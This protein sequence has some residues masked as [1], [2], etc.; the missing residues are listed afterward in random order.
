MLESL[1][2]WIFRHGRRQTFAENPNL[3]EEGQR[4]AQDLLLSVSE[5][6]IPKPTE[7]L[8]SP[9][10]RA[11][12]TFDLLA[13]SLDL[14]LTQWSSLR[15]RTSNESAQAFTERVEEAIHILSQKIGQT[16]FICSHH[17]WIEECMIR[18]PSSMP[19]EKLTDGWCPGHYK[20]FNIKNG[21]WELEGSGELKASSN[22][23]K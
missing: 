16:V 13:E 15:Q 17:D 22:E 7:I 2:I 21:L 5:K 23:R 6:K 11:V 12:Q 20:F 3:N 1:S 4:Q 19:S 10:R 8:T 14:P 18:I 9:L